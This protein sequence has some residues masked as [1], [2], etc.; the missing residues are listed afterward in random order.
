M[1]FFFL[2]LREREPA[3]SSS[4]I[5]CFPKKQEKKKYINN[6]PAIFFFFC[7][8]ASLVFSFF[9]SLSLSLNSP[10]SPYYN[11]DTQT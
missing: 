11:K 4:V 6:F 9:L 5:I 7:S 2:F 8:H 10:K 3:L 1:P